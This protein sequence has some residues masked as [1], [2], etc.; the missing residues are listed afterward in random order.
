MTATNTPHPATKPGPLVRRYLDDATAEQADTTWSVRLLEI[1]RLMRVVSHNAHQLAV[2]VSRKPRRAT[3]HL[4][5][6]DT[7]H[8]DATGPYA[9]AWLTHWHGSQGQTW[10]DVRA[11]IEDHLNAALATTDDP[12]RLWTQASG[13]QLRAWD[14]SP[15]HHA[16]RLLWTV[17]LLDQR[18]VQAYNALDQAARRPDAPLDAMRAITD[19]FLDTE[20][21]DYL[22]QPEQDRTRH[23]YL[24]LL[25]LNTWLAQADPTGRLDD[26]QPTTPDIDPDLLEQILIAHVGQNAARTILSSLDTAHDVPPGIDTDLRGSMRDGYDADAVNTTLG[27]INAATGAH[28]ICLWD[29]CQTTTLGDIYAGDSNFY[30][31]HNGLVHEL[32]GDLYDWLNGDPHDPDTALNPGTPDTWTGAPTTHT[33]DAL[34]AHDGRLNHA[35]HTR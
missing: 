30:I 7:K 1:T 21:A 14:L 29:Y 26:A 23:P 2:S 15:S 3:I 16:N 19:E 10:D 18:A 12:G 9:P 35:T 24:N 4:I 27:H 33:L 6:A 13:A 5:A 25:R 20:H 32:G 34:P 22:E 31:V 8:H 11:T 17:H 28:V